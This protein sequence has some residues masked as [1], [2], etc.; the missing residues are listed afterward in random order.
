MLFEHFKD[1]KKNTKGVNGTAS[2]EKTHV[3][4][5]HCVCLITQ[6]NMKNKTLT[7]LNL[8]QV[9]NERHSAG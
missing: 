6:S 2:D 3:C 4:G 9:T 5:L 7:N 1:E 8:C